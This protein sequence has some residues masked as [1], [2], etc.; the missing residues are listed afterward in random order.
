[1]AARLI[2]LLMMFFTATVHADDFRPFGEG[3]PLPWP[4][5]WAKDCP[6]EWSNLI[7]RYTMVDNSL[8]EE[9]A[10]RI[11][12]ISHHRLH[13]LRISRYSPVGELLSD[14][15]SF[16]TE[17]Q[18]IM[19]VYLRPYAPGQEPLWATIRLFFDDNDLV[20]AKD[21]LVP[22]LSLWHRREGVM[23]ETQYRLV[24]RPTDIRWTQ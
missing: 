22:I 15:F 3:L 10:I 14:G 12:L 13:V 11:S 8:G 4:F 5:P 18:R 19:R 9:V 24:R 1:M 17:N 7:G 2:A 21:R 20:C 6:V 23:S 16:I